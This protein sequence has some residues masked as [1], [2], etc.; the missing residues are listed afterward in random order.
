MLGPS[1]AASRAAKWTVPLP[2]HLTNRLGVVFFSAC[3]IAIFV[4]SYVASVS[5]LHSYIGY[6]WNPPPTE[7]Y[8]FS[9]VLA[10]VPSFFI[11]T[12]FRR[13]STLA[14]CIFYPTFVIPAAILPF[15]VLKEPPEVMAP[16][17]L[18][19][20][21]G[22]SLLA[23]FVRGP[24]WRIRP[25]AVPRQLLIVGL[26]LGTIGLT[27]LVA[28]ANGFQV[29][30][31]FADVYDRRLAARESASWL[32]G[33]GL[34]FLASSFAPL[35]LALGVE[36]KNRWLFIVGSVGL[37]SI[38]SFSGT[39]SSLFTPLLMVGFYWLIRRPRFQMN[40][41]L[42]LLCAGMASG[43]LLWTTQSNLLLTN[44]LTYR[45]V[46]SRGVALAHYWKVYDGEPIYMGDS[47]FASALGIT[48]A[49][50]KSFN[51]GSQYGYTSEDNYNAGIWASG[52]ANFGW[53][54]VLVASLGAA[55]V[56]KLLDALSRVGLRTTCLL[57]A[58][59]FAIFWS[60]IS[61]EG[62]VITQGLVITLPFLFFA[63]RSLGRPAHA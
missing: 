39:K 4:W 59:T 40:W 2:E 62:S 49:P 53:P 10:W 27:V 38:F 26:L 31:S 9:L 1:S 37:L 48:P 43:T 44:L 28:A 52:F 30:L 46:S 24:V 63:V 29:N 61:F 32:T 51:V 33:Y 35:S 50:A 16:V 23:L 8:V 15:H 6:F 42:G 55:L 25:P 3:T 57:V 56:L 11:S 58:A 13:P 21:L 36:L 47:S 20:V 7:W 12:E 17:A 45:M 5:P 54:G 19:G 41:L 34:A 22:F 14:V 60:D 18:M